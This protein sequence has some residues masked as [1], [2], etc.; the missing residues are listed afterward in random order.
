[1]ICSWLFYD[2]FMM[3]SWLFDDLF[4]ICSWS[5]NHF[6]MNFPMICHRF[7]NELFGDLGACFLKMCFWLQREACFFFIFQR[8]LKELK[9]FIDDFFMICSWFFYYL[10]MILSRFVL[11]LFL[12]FFM[13]FHDIFYVFLCKCSCSSWSWP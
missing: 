9:W 11:D 7:F 4:I 6:L 8:N 12:S 3:C 1:M 5:F 2:L 10:L 13:F